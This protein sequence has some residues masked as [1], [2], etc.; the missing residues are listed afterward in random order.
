MSDYEDEL[1]EW[2]LWD[3]DE[4]DADDPESIDDGINM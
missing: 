2:L 4:D 3:C 1:L